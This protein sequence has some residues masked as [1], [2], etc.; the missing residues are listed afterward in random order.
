MG[1]FARLLRRSGARTAETEEAP[2]AGTP[3]D[4]TQADGQRTDEAAAGP[5]TDETA[6][7]TATEE[8][9]G[10]QE[11]SGGAAGGSASGADGVGIPKQQSAEAAG[12]DAGEGART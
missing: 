11:P 9:V 5:A 3:A 6:P 8:S 1:V 2:S 10:E 7:A 4:G 12:S